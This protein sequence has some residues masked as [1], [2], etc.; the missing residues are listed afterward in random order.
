[1]KWLSLYNIDTVIRVQI[2]GETVSISHSA[3][4]LKKSM[5]TTILPAA[6]SK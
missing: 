3:N 6:T 2:L 1:M 4:T 5:N